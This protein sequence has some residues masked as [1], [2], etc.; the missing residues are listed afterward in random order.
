M[1][2]IYFATSN[3]TKVAHAALALKPFGINVKQATI[4]L[5][6]SRSED[7]AEIALE[8]ATQAYKKFRKPLLVEDSG[9]FIE[10][11]GGFPM[12]HI[13]FSLKTL[14]IDGILKAMGRAKNRNCEWRMALAYVYG[15]G[16]HKTFTFIEKGVIADKPRRVLRPMMSDY[17][18]LYVPKLLNAKNTKA[19]SDMSEKDMEDWMAYFSKNNH[20][21]Q[22]GR[23]L[24]KKV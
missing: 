16:K 14:G 6:E 3:A 5:A 1:R 20:F 12:T 15:K 8:K 24:V 22:L 7:P 2:T 17:W 11:L 19:L 21:L 10:A 23:W 9:F 4:D 13:K 18:R